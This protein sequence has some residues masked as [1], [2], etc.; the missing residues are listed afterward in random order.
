MVLRRK[1]QKTPSDRTR[2][3]I[4]RNMPRGN[5]CHVTNDGNTTYMTGSTYIVANHKCYCIFSGF[6]ECRW[7]L[8][9]D[10]TGD[11]EKG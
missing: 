11:A 7:G 6:A 8:V 5:R 9:S 4:E 1:R 3:K 10:E 2:L